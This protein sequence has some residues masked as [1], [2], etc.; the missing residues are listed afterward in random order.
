MSNAHP[1]TMKIKVSFCLCD[2]RTIHNACREDKNEVTVK[3]AYHCSFTGRVIDAKTQILF[4]G[5]FVQCLFFSVF[6]VSVRE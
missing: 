6:S 1:V 2:L 5:S 3:V 4:T